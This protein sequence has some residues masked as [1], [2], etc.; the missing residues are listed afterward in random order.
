MAR[1][2]GTTSTSASSSHSDSLLELQELS[3][4]TPDGSSLLVQGLNVG[5]KSGSPLLVMGPSGVR[6]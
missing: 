6:A 1:S 4:V 2:N 3:V 5:V